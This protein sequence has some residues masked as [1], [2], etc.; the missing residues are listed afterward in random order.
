MRIFKFGGASIKNANGVRNLVRVLKYEGTENTFVVVSAMGKMTN[1]FEKVV[2]TYLNDELN[3]KN[4]I[5]EIQFFHQE[6]LSDLFEHEDSIHAEI[7][8]LFGKL[9]GF[10]IHN[11]TKEYSFV[12]D[13]VVCF[14]EL[15]STKI[16]SSFLDKSNIK[17]TWLDSRKII[18]TDSNYR[19]AAVNWKETQLNCK[20]INQ[21]K[22]NITQGFI[23]QDLKGNGTTLGREGSDFTA[24]I[25]AYCL[26]AESVT[27][28]KDVDGV[29]NADPRV[30][31]NTILLNQISYQEA[32]EMAFYGA[33]V[34]HPKTIKPLENKKI[35][36]FVRS[37]E[38][39]ENKGTKVSKGINIEPIMSCF[40]VKKN[41]ILVSI[42]AKDFSFMVEKNLSSIF[43]LLHQ[44]KLKVNLI[45]NSAISF[46]VCLE[47]NY[48][49]FTSFYN[50]LKPNFKV[51][52][53]ENVSLFTIRHFDLKS[54][55]DIEKK[56]TV[57]LKQ[58]SRETVQ[59]IIDKKNNYDN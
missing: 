26:D 22:L 58:T 41:Q 51:R 30:F 15:I 52:F 49:S 47:D 13:Q 1:A 59:L 34:I 27:I 40:I 53:N 35:P 57:L 9:Q 6:I 17:N 24:G 33:S 8:T 39:L 32:I 23:S 18:K 55:K 38:N 12:Y 14:G 54:I 5:N 21:Q 29:L 46:S 37:F 16:I 19:N 10:L 25:L 36:L 4:S 43:D 3:F 2:D 20:Q 50:E 11:S 28:W 48:S 7:N 44:Y 31:E 42:S 56:G 45:Q